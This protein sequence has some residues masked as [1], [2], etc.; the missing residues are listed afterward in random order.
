MNRPGTPK[1]GWASAPPDAGTDIG[2]SID[3]PRVLPE[4]TRL[5]PSG[6][7]ARPCTPKSSAVSVVTF[8]AAIDDLDP[9]AIVETELM[10]HERD[11]VAIRRDARIAQVA[12]RLVQRRAGRNSS[13]SRVFP[14]SCTIAI[15][16][17]SGDQSA[18]RTSSEMARGELPM[19]MRASVPP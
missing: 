18:S 10:L 6:V 3:E 2:C 19:V 9:T 8:P 16:E 15:A 1:T 17:P 14:R 4:N 12:A 13:R 5:E 11:A 7:H